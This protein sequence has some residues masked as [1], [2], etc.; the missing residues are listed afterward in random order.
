MASFT[1]GHL[2]PDNNPSPS[3]PP[4]ASGSGSGGKDK[5]KVG[6]QPS[7]QQVA[8]AVAPPLKKGP[9]SL[10]G[11]QRR[12]FAP[13]QSPA[14]H[15]DA[16][17]IAATF[18]DIAAHVLRES[19]CLLPLGFSATVNQRGAIS[20]TVTAKATPAASY[21]PYFD[22]LT[23]ALNQSFP[24]G[25]NPWCTPVLTPTAVQL[26]IH[27]LPLRFLPQDEEELF[28]YI[29]QAILNNKATPVLSARYL[30]ADR[31]S[32]SIKQAT[33]V[34]VT[35]DPQHVSALTSGVFI[36]SQKRKVDLAFSANRTSQ[37]RQCWRYRHAHQRWPAT[38][39]TCPICA[40]HHTRASHRCQNPTCLRGGNNK[41]VP[42]CCPTSP[43]HCCN[44]GNDHSATFKE[45]LARP[46]PASPTRPTSPVPP[47]QDPMDMAVDGCPAPSTPPARAGPTEVDLVTSRQPPPAGPPRPGTI[48]GFGGPLP[49]EAQS[50][51]PAPSDRRVR[52][53]NE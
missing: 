27:G 24:V 3:Y 49:L 16:P 4:A 41:P 47:G 48:Q 23:R 32:R 6:K 2:H 46:S 33:A 8:S 43:P 39:P 52:P 53:G 18:P 17:S 21:T 50:P 1:P 30:N 28:P 37:C 10:P 40:L 34:V 31:D 9:P 22:S 51:S 12:F 7:P 29:R 35:I 20:L 19:N 14:P 38:H 25:E 36:L 11:A 26:A 5:K 15:P 45:C 44:C 13:R 42:S